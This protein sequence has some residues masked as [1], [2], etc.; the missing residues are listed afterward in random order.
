MRCEVS[1]DVRQEH[2]VD[3]IPIP[4]DLAHADA[5]AFVLESGRDSTVSIVSIG[6][7]L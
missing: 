3:Y 7:A 5:Q 1:V 4:A 2:G 6:V